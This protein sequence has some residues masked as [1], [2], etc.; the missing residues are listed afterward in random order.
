M[1]KIRRHN[2]PTSYPRASAF[3]VGFSTSQAWLGGSS[4]GKTSGK[5]A[6]LTQNCSSADSSL[7]QEEVQRSLSYGCQRYQRL[8][9][10]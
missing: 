2:S 3:P 1:P 8:R 9:V 7:S 6:G 5:E 4:E 10:L